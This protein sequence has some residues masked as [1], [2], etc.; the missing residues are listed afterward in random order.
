MQPSPPIQ[1]VHL[2]PVLDKMLIELLESLTKE[3]WFKPTIAKRWL[4]KD[5]AAHLLDTNIRTLSLSRDRHS[6]QPTNPINSYQELV[7]YLNEL[8]AIWV[9]A[10]RRVSPELLTEFLRTTGKQFSDYLA[11]LDPYEEA[12]FSVAWAGEQTSRNWF[13]VAR[14]YTEKYLHQLQIREAVSRPGLMTRELFFPFIDTLMQALPYT[15]RNT[16]ADIGTVVKVTV[17]TDIGGDWYLEMKED[18]WKLSMQEPED[19]KASLEIDPVTSWK[20]F[21]KGMSPSEAR[22]KIVIS[23]NEEL[24]TVT[25]Q[26][27]SVMA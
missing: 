16:M 8:N 15:Y 17:T 12:I 20:L 4:V 23:G 3:E 26:M 18:G 10:Y 19:P 6:L 25:L 14:E 1:T 9:N 21:S 7:D 5:I 22:D 27:L 13:H 2:F 24:A 11:T